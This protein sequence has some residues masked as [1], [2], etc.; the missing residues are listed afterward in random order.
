MHQNGYFI[1]MLSQMLV[2][3]SAYQRHH[4]GAHM[5]LTSYLYVSVHYRRNNG[6]SSEVAP[7]SIVT[8]WIKLDVVNHCFQQLLAASVVYWLVCW[9]LVPKIVGL[10]P[11]KAVGFFGRKNPQHAFLQRGSKA[12][13]PMSQVCSM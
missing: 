5:I 7:I 1:V 3:V 13:C 2:H 6:I 10:N 11:A 12:V 8:L 4:Q 9:P